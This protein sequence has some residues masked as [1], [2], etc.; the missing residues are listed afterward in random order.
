MLPKSRSQDHEDEIIYKLLGE[1]KMGY[2]VDVGAYHPRTLSVTWSFKQIGWRGISI[3]PDVEMWEELKKANPDDHNVCC[4]IGLIPGSVR[5][6]IS[7]PGSTMNKAAAERRGKGEWRMV[8]VKRLDSVIEEAPPPAELK[9][10]LKVDVEGQEDDVLKSNDWKLYR[11]DVICVEI[12][13]PYS[14]RKVRT[15]TNYLETVGYKKVF[16][17]GNNGYYIPEEKS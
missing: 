14:A 2:F 12:F 4:A 3:E 6:L 8:E 9:W 5:M 15:E 1:P 17:Q 10:F 7:G 11:P 13:Q 16:E